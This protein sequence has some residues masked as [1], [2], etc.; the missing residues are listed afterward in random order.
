MRLS[1]IFAIA[2][3][4]LAAAVLCLVCARFAVGMI[5]DT[6]RI[7][8]RDTLDENG[9][10]WAEV[11]AN[12]LQVFLAGT[13]PSEATRF[14]ALSVAGT[15]VDAA[16]VIDQ[17]LVE[18]HDRVEPPR[19]SMEIL[20][21][22][23]GVSLIGLVP[24]AMDREAFVEVVEDAADG[25]PVADF[26]EAADYPEPDTWEDATAYALRSLKELER[27]KISLD[28]AR[29]EI[30][31]M[32]DS[33][34]EKADV[35][36]RLSRRLPEGVSLALDISAPRPVIAPFA[37]RFVIED[38]KARFDACSADTEVARER[39]IAA[40]RSAGQAGRA[41]C[42]IG[43]GVPSPRWAEAAEL[44]IGALA[45][46][47]GGEVTFSD[48]DISLV[49][50]E[51]VEQRRFD[52]IVGGL[53]SALPEVFALHAVLPRSPDKLSHEAPEFTITLSPEGL[54]Q[55]RGRVFAADRGMIDTFA[56]ARFT[57]DGVHMT[58]R[59]DDDL[60]EGWTLRI[61]AAID[62]LSRLSHGVVLVSPDEV[63]ITGSTGEADAGNAISAMLSEKLGKGARFSIDVEYVEAL[64]PVASLP[65]PEECEARIAEVQKEHKI[66]FEPGSANIDANASDIMDRIADILRE[67]GDIT[68]EIGGHTDSQGREVMNQ[69][70]S[71]SRA[72]TVLNELRMRRVLTSAITAVGYG[73]S[74]PIADNDTEEGREANRR[75]EFKVIVPEE[76]AEDATEGQETLA[77]GGE[78]SEEQA[79]TDAGDAGDDEIPTDGG[80]TAQ[81]DAS[82]DGETQEDGADEQD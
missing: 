23:G 15:I 54:V 18:D 82:T 48:A 52:D 34:A 66:T 46:L 35:E 36:A 7:T 21:N 58:A 19:F 72:E 32:T 12:G 4:F 71:L 55:L 25:A 50:D 47:G 62:A 74:R 5:E 61:L 39:I 56:R 77:T 10:T 13:A 65:T 20:R 24:A 69:Q 30:T 80:E 57:S 49:A 51:T 29:V 43:L 64:D 11:D 68:L 67:C 78:T 14:K 40:A 45:E 81:A 6:T 53:E 73:E 37:L 3:V 44:A 1:K 33:A 76:V 28:A 22:E 17:M 16:R 8:V 59:A 60:P 27:T 41:N 38:G 75:I 2:G 42:L 9:L 79:G 70:L 63:S 26:L 31:A